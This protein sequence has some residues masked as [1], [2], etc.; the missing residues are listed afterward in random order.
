MRIKLLV[1]LATLLMAGGVH[2][3]TLTYSGTLTFQLSTLPGLVGPG[4][5]MAVVN[6]SASGLPASSIAIFAGAFGPVSDSLPVTNSGTINSVIFTSLA[7][8]SGTPLVGGAGAPMGLTGTSKICLVFAPCAYASVTVPLTSVGGTGFGVGGTQVVTGSVSI[9][10]QHNPWTLT[11]PAMTIHSPN[12]NVTTP[13]FPSGYNTAGGAVQLVTVTKTFTSL[14]TA[15]PELPLIGVI[16][17]KLVP[18]PGTMLL[19]GAGVAGLAI[20]G[21]SRKR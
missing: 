14:T 11:A 13:T 21:R 9:T 18:E 7:N 3:A 6:G 17:L 19:L 10:M 8:A 20:L 15:F 16:S 12:S 2:A 4:G 1:A 5:G